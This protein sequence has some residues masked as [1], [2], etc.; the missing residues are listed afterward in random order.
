MPCARRCGLSLKS[1]WG[2]DAVAGQID[3]KA[4]NVTVD[5]QGSRLTEAEQRINGLDASLGQ[6]VTK[7]SSLTNNSESPRLGGAKRN[8]RGVDPEGRP[9]RGG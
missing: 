3:N 6:T 2:F 8:K 4:D 7:G 5:S 9:A 1:I